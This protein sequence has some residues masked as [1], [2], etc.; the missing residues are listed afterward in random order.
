MKNR[1]IEMKKISI[2]TPCYNEELNVHDLYLAVK[3]QFAL[4]ENYTYEHIFI[5]NSSR[6]KTVEII[7]ELCKKDENVKLIVNS[8]NFGPSNS[9]FYGLMQSNSDATILMVAD[10]QDP[11]EM[12]RAFLAKWEAGFKIVIGVK[13]KSKEN[14]LMF[15]MRQVYYKTIRKI[16]EID[17]IDNFTGF[18]L[19]DRDVMDI[20]RNL[21]DPSPYFRGMICEIGFEKAFLTYT[22]PLRKKGVSKHSLYMLY[23]IA[24][25]GITSNSKVPLR[26]ATLLGFFIA[27]MSMLVAIVYFILKLT[28]WNT[29]DLGLAPLVIGLFFFSSV[30][31]IFIGI[32][33]EYIGNIYTQ[34][35]NRPLVIEKK[36]INFDDDNINL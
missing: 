8:R 9:V 24:M 26:I 27:S 2:V 13:N 34:V 1:R 32:L 30:Q 11:P 3:Q 4:L 16:S 22:Q 28:F 29:F 14:K 10:F 21:E 23:D 25:L 5:D 35:L 6:D 36:R 12:I 31:L 7:E 33:G 18:G 20:L 19:Y 15:F 17:H